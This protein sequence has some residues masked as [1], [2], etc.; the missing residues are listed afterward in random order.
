MDVGCYCINASRL[1]AGEPQQ[2]LGT[3]VTNDAGVDVRFAATILS[4]GDVV[5]QFDTG[6]DIPVREELELIG[7]RGQIVVHDPWHGLEPVIELRRDGGT[8]TFPIEAADSYRLELENLGDA[9]IGGAEP[10]LGRAD[11]V[12]QARVL[13]AL[14]RSAREQR[15]IDLA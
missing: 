2:V 3:H 12:G 1:F 6:L 11:A 9:I 8:E 4:A 15:P 13:E 5:T 14:F 10:L 7:D